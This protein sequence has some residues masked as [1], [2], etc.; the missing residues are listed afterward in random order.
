LAE[1][2]FELPARARIC[3][4]ASVSEL[5]IVE[6]A[7]GDRPCTVVL[8]RPERTAGVNDQNLYPAVRDPVD[9]QSRARLRIPDRRDLV[10]RR[11]V[12]AVCEGV[13]VTK[14]PEVLWSPDPRAGATTRLGRF[15]SKA[16]REL[17][18]D[19]PDYQRAWA[20]SVEDLEGFWS[21]VWDEFD[22]RTSA[23]ASRVLSARQMPGARWFEG[24]RLNYAEHALT[25]SA[26]DGPA[27]VSESQTTGFSE[28]TSV[29]LREQV[30]RVRA[31]LSDLGLG[32]GDRVAAY[33]PNIPETVILFLAT[34]S[35]GA[36][37]SSCAPEFGVRAVVERFG[38]I[39]P[40][41]LVAADGYVYGKRTV[42]RTDE[43][44][45]IAAQLPSLS[46]TVVLRYSGGE[47]ASRAMDGKRRVLDWEELRS[48]PGPL[49]F[50]QV[51]FDHPLYI[52]FSSGTTG[53]PK[54]IVH[55]HGGILIEH[56]KALGLQSDLGARDR[57]FWFTT[58]GWM[59][60]NYLVSGLLVGSC[61]VLF[62]GDPGYPDLL[63]TW[64]LA[65]RV[66]VDWFGTSAPFLMACRKAGLV[67]GQSLD[68]SSVR[69]VGSTGAPLP[70]EGSRWVYS[71]VGENLML[72][73]ISGGTD[74]CTAFIGGSPLV[75]VRAGEIPCRWLGASVEAFGPDGTAVIGSEGELVVTAPMPSM[76][77]C[78][79][80]DTDGERMR[81]TYF[82]VFPGVWRHGDW[83]T[84]TDRGSCVISGR[85]DATL[86]RGGV[87]IGTAEMYSVIED[88]DGVAD[89]LIVHLEDPEGGPGRLVLLVVRPDASTAGTEELVAR[90][91]KAVREALS[92]RHVPDEVYVVD[93]IPRTLS[94]KKLELPVKR[95]LSGEDPEKV[96][97][98]E[99]L[100]DPRALDAIAD[101]ARSV[102]D[103]L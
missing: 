71:S 72:S 4:P 40:K 51:P 29:E 7:F 14:L 1:F 81:S 13:D 55:C 86:N 43:L 8:L 12:L 83:V 23:P 24:A 60:W 68:L 69:A 57:F 95:I 48:D 87:R 90:I 64:R 89:S 3:A 36:I 80:G 98:R 37:F 9:E 25:R 79:W 28:M 35:L 10:G 17:G 41:V 92:P 26:S 59:M 85:S 82:D 61:I 102:R 15:L 76:P 27:I 49:E 33:M 73:S 46:A 21:A 63:E 100:T 58:T 78:L 5:P 53:L 54:P 97:S 22:I 56:L 93:A 75:E 19:L 94:G 67:P 34:A 45:E 50:E 11:R 38:Q 16:E 47:P 44:R 42:S 6:L 52:L 84:V 30:S 32:R 2:F 70:A 62:D 88:V 20:W 77:V 91:A 66:R 99:A 65:E 74:V 96:A 31:G 101:L 18:V 103:D 39:E